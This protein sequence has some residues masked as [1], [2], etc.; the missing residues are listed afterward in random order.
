M[1]AE[2]ASGRPGRGN[3]LAQEQI[4][5]RLRTESLL[6]R[7][8]ITPLLEASQVSG[9]SVDLRIGFQF[10]L[11]RRA[12]LSGIE[13]LDASAH[14]KR[15][16]YQERVTLSRGRCLHLHPGEFILGATLEYIRLPNDLS[17]YVTSRSSWGRAGL[18]IATAISVAP[19]F[20]GVITLELANLGSVPLALHPGV[21]IAQLVLH[22][23]E[24]TTPYSGRYRCPTG[25]EA[26]RVD[27]DGE[28][29]FWAPKHT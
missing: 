25:P 26:G 24:P 5:A 9:A 1:T 2:L 12:N 17:G 16:K 3:L 6:E 4:W 7:L 13:P 10:V 14:K 23:T 11:P 20:M 8:I 22:Y 27:L 28:L 29:R 19:G 21:R 15:H 18:A